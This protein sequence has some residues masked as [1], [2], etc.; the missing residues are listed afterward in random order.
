MDT[1]PHLYSLREA[2]RQILPLTLLC[3]ATLTPFTCRAQVH[4]PPDK[5]PATDMPATPPETNQ[6]LASY[7]GQNV[8]S[9]V[10]AGHPDLK[11]EELEPVMTQKA[12]QP[13]SGRKVEE[14]A[15]ALKIAGHFDQ[16]HVEVQPDARGITIYFIL[17]PASWFG[18]FNFPGAERFPYSQLVQT[19]N[20]PP[21]WPYSAEEVEK[22]RASLQAFFQQQGYFQA[23]VKSELRA[24][25]DRGIVNVDFHCDLDE[26]AKF[27]SAVIAGAPDGDEAK[28]DKKLTGIAARGRG[29]SIRP[30]KTYYRSNVDKAVRYLQS[31]LVKQGYLGAQVKLEG[32]EYNPDTNRADIHFSIQPGLVTHVQITGAHLWSWTRKNLLPVYQGVGVDDETVQEGQQA[33]IS[34]F[35]GKGYFDVK[36]NSRLE[37]RQSTDTVIYQIEKE[38]KHKVSSVELAGNSQLPSSQLMPSI[39]VEKKHLFSQGKFSNELARKS[40][41]NLSG[42]YKA[43]GFSSVKVTSSVKDNGKDIGVTFRVIEGPRDVVNGVNIEGARTFSESQFAPG[44]LKVRAG[45]PYSSAH[46]EEDRNTILANYYRAGFLNATIR[47]TATEVSKQDP[48]RINVV[49]HISEGPRVTTKELV[50]LGRNHT[51]PRVIQEDI[52]QLEPGKPLTEQALLA[53]GSKLYERPGVFDWAEVDTKRQVTTQTNEDVLVKLHEAKRNEIQYGFG[54]EVIQRGGS[55]PGGTVAVPNLPPIGLPQ[56]FT[57]SQS[58]FYGPRGTVQY[59][60]NNL[61][62]KA[63]SITA[64][65]M[66]GRLD[67]RFA[68]YYINPDLRWSSWKATTQLSFERNE[69]NPIFSSRIRLASLEVQ[70]PLDRAQKNILFFRYSYSKTDLTHVLVEDLVPAR[71]QHVQLS[72]W[73]VNFTRDTRD[74]P[75]DEHRGVLHS[76]ELDFDSSKLGSNVDFAKLTAQAAFYKEKFHRIVWANSIRIGLA[77]PYASSF[78]PLSEAFFTGGGNSLRGFPLLSAGPQRPVEVCSNGVSGC[79]QFIQVPT[80]GNEMLVLNSE[81]R[82]PLDVVKKSLGVVFFYDGGNVFPYVGFHDFTSLY[83]NNVGFGLRYATPVGPIR[84]DVGQNLNP[85]NGVKATQY[86]ITIG[87]AF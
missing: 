49:Y 37:K 66:A 79:N 71:D 63:E 72:T 68:L 17:E 82:I 67:Q 61:R 40:V 11:L 19:A 23:Q 51:S 84:I 12:N 57:T 76:V 77:Q 20:Y 64:T 45:Q 69:Q 81:A 74:N 9:V 21:E 22:D 5:P 43:E 42:V 16:V 46:V 29:A 28:L 44:G 33:L 36:V 3:L 27:G 52:Q 83:S 35:Q 78:V 75:M 32:A 30:G 26:K 48:H 86:F 1:C 10:L 65:A 50:T 25:R 73:S 31:L 34:Y 60:R 15:K 39:S 2:A 87:Q 38:G 62:G 53:S 4:Q 41:N 54:F 24:D 85:V 58:T 7:E 59:T 14:T 55:V 56:N 6:M 13:F 18:I 47:E 70:R 8:S 80:G